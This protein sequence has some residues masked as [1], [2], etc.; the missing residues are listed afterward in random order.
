[1]ETP[2]NSSNPT[3]SEINTTASEKSLKSRVKDLFS[4]KDNHLKFKWLGVGVLLTL[5]IVVTGFYLMGGVQ[6]QKDNTGVG[7]VN[8]PTYTQNISPSP[9]LV[10]A[11]PIDPNAWGI[12]VSKGEIKASSDLVENNLI[13]ATKSEYR[14]TVYKRNLQ[15]GTQTKILE[16]DEQKKAE[17]SGNLWEGLPP[18]IALSPNKKEIAFV[19]QEGLKLYDLQSG[20]T[21]VFIK[22]TV[23]PTNEDSPP[24]WSISSLSGTYSL[25]RPLWSSNGRYVSF[26]QGH[27]EGA[28]FGLIDSQTGQYFPISLG[29]GY[30]NF[31]WSP[32]DTAF[33]KP[34][35]GGY[36]GTGLFASASDITKEAVDLS[37]KFGKQNASFFEVNYSP[38]G[39]KL[40]FTFSDNEESGQSSVGI[41]NIDGTGFTVLDETGGNSMPFFSSNSSEVFY[42]QKRGEKQVLM[43]YDLATKKSSDFVVLPTEFNSWRSASWTNEGYLAVIGVSSSSGLTVGG[44]S[45]RLVIFDLQNRKVVY[46]TSTFDQFTTF[47]GFS[48]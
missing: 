28:S 25:A 44:D 17:K 34:M 37:S 5:I 32:T 15:T 30:R 40:A 16:F 6:K 39:R 23:K 2:N 22:E 8:K 1:M 21:K 43:K 14:S 4:N 11:K 33:V 20:S 48:N 38:D 29:G 27:Y 42:V 3:P 24:Q 35:Y 46:A 9:T 31:T 12:T 41:V 7:Q 26:L 45:T 36:E 18:N 10:P 47:A 13:Y 19:D